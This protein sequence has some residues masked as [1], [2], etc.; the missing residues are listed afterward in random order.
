M[1]VSMAMRSPA[2][3]CLPSTTVRHV[4]KLMQEHRI[5]CVVVVARDGSITGIVT[6][7][8]LALRALGQGQSADIPVERV[9]TR[10]VARVFVGADLDDVEATMSDRHVRRLPVVDSRGNVHGVISLDDVVRSI[11]HRAGDVSDLLVSHAKVG[12]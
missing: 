10:N 1:K 3:T 6:D 9:M 4:C 12:S 11:S 7:R 5:G 8:D 2:V